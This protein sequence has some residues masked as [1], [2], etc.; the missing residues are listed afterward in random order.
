MAQDPQ[1]AP[2]EV[3]DVVTSGYDPLADFDI[4]EDDID[5]SDGQLGPHTE[6]QAKAWYAQKSDDR[7]ASQR[8]EDLFTAWA[9]RRSILLAILQFLDEPR[10]SDL[11]DEKVAELQENN[12]SVF[13]GYNYSLL[14]CE[15]GAIKKISED[16]SDF[17]EEAE[18]L[19][20]IVEIDGSRFYKPTDGKQVFWL[21]TDEG[22]AYLETDNPFGRLAELIASE[23]DY[24][25]IY[26]SLLEFCG[27]EAGRNAEELAALIDNDPLVQKPRKYFSSF[28]KKLEDCGAL[29]W[30]KT[31]HTSDLGNKAV[32]LL[33]SEDNAVDP[34]E[35]VT[36]GEE[37]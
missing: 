13:S 10:R 26:K 24:R 3:F 12:I 9:T 5:E 2:D 4:D 23:Q 34:D 15:A 32:Q 28:V 20:D 37:L 33:F 18:Q 21:I 16:G 36:G 14:L 6:F 22:R 30:A 1:A 35:P 25:R 7:S 11:L 17:D 19:P 27:N 8:I 29:V 31:W